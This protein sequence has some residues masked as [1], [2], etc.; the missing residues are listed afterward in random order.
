MR[1]PRCLTD[2]LADATRV[3]Q[4]ARCPRCSAVFVVAA[5]PHEPIPGGSPWQAPEATY[6]APPAAIAPVAKVAPTPVPAPAP[7]RARTMPAAIRMALAGLAGLVVLAAA[8]YLG[9]IAPRAAAQ[10]RMDARVHEKAYTAALVKLRD[11]VDR[12]REDYPGYAPADLVTLT[13]RSLAPTD[14][15]R[16]GA[17]PALP[18]DPARAHAPYL[19][20]GII[21]ANPFAAPGAELSQH[22]RYIPADA[23][24][25]AA[26]GITTFPPG[27]MSTGTAW[28]AY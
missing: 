21:P 2:G 16:L 7:P 4:Q 1:C 14:F 22:W 28:D 18:P 17:A 11:A 23:T 8:L 10:R 13:R 6:T 12:F 9:V 15:V 20:G 26:P 27:A 19:A 24:I 5:I 3:G 25:H